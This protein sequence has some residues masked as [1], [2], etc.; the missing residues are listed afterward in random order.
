MSLAGAI[1]LSN[2]VLMPRVLYR[3][4][5]SNA[6]DEQIDRIQSRPRRAIASKAPITAANS[7]VLFGGYMGCGWK[8]WKDEVGIERLKTVQAA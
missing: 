6:T 5:L 2:V 4:K 1:Y 8:R 3:L 7:S